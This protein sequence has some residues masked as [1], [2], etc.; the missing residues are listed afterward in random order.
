MKSEERDKPYWILITENGG[1]IESRGIDDPFIHTVIRPRGL[2]A[3]FLVLFGWLEWRIHVTGS[4]EAHRRV[5]GPLFS[6]GFALC[7]AC[8]KS[9]VTVLP[10]CGHQLCNECWPCPL[11]KQEAAEGRTQ[12]HGRLQCA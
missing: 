9:P 10:S 11:C 8:E 6:P 3:A 2:R 1:A 5:F 4:A 7:G 12:D